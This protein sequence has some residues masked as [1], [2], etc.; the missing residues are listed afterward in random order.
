MGDSTS[1][2]MEYHRLTRNVHVVNETK[3]HK[4][5]MKVER[6]R[7]ERMGGKVEIPYVKERVINGFRM[8]VVLGEQNTCILR[9]E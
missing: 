2:I 5:H 3:K 8:E 7:I 6:E 9:K 1:F 4:P